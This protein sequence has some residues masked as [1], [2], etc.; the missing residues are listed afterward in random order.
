[1]TARVLVVVLLVFSTVAVQAAPPAAD[2]A[3]VAE[4]RRHFERG[5]RLFKVSRYREALEEFKEA[6]LAKSD[7]VFLYNVAQCH[8]LLGERQDAITFYR[9]YLEA[10][11]ESRNRSEVERRIADL[12]A[13]AQRETPVT[14]PAPTLAPPPV[15]TAPTSAPE[16]AVSVPVP[17]AEQ[18]PVYKRW[19]FWAGLAAV[20][21]G[22]VTAV[23]L[24]RGGSDC[25][26]NLD[27]CRKL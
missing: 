13:A 4:A 5:Q 22:T 25:G 18:R 10:A 3:V 6:Y 19:W 27:L 24:S 15:I 11:P 1:M 8:R 20:A 7:P 23:A 21:A 26:P 2:A 9:R 17:V 14:P 16:A 12:E